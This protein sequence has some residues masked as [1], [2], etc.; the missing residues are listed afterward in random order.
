MS[1]ATPEQ[2]EMARIPR[3]HLSECVSV[4]HNLCGRRTIH[5]VCDCKTC[6]AHLKGHPHE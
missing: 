5:K 4:F 3:D 2:L 1:E 6:R